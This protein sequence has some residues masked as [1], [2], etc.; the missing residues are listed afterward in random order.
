MLED[1]IMARKQYVKTNGTGYDFTDDSSEAIH[2]TSGVNAKKLR[3]RLADQFTSYFLAVE[4]DPSGNTVLSA[5][6]RG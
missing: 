6:S 2:F 5:V 3:D 4:T 1:P